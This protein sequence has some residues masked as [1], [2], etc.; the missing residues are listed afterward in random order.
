[1]GQ[2]KYENLLSSSIF[3]QLMDIDKS[4]RGFCLYLR[5]ITYNTFENY[6]LIKLL[7]NIL[8]LLFLFLPLSL[9]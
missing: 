3:F 9:F 7:R 6:S 4:I 1:M 2:D 8:T 5:M